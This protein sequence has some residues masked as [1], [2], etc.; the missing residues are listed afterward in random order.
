MR[1]DKIYWVPGT[2]LILVIWILL[3]MLEIFD[4]LLVP[5][6]IEFFRGVFL[7]FTDGFS[8]ASMFSTLARVLIAFIISCTVGI[9]I[10]L[11]LGYYQHL[12]KLTEGLIDFF[13]SIPG[14]A[15]FPLFILFFGIND[16]SRIMVSLFIGV[17]IILLNTKYGIKNSR[18]I[19]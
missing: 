11:I 19:K 18:G 7:L 2:L 4:P 13:R 14:I 3:F 1:L 16:I 15:V 9:T 6:P 17:P 10:G 8:I 5:S 12:D